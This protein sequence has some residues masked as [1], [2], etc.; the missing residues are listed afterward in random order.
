MARFVIVGAGL[1]G[2]KA[3][4][5]LRE[6]GLRRAGRADRRRARTPLRAAAAVQGLP[7]GQDR[8]RDK[9]FVH[10][11]ELVRRARR[12]TAARARGHARSTRAAHTRRRSA[13]GDR[14]GYDKLLLATGSRRA[15]LA[16]P[17]RRPRRRAL[18]APLDDSDRLRGRAARRRRGVVVDRRRLD[19]AGGRRRRPRRPAPR[20]P[21]RAAPTCRC[22]A[23]SAPEL[24]A[25][26]RRPAPRA[27]RRPAARRRRRRDHRRRTAVRPAYAW[28][29][30]PRS[31][32]DAV[33]VG[34]GAAPERRARRG[35]RP[36]RRQ[37]R[38]WSTRAC[39][40]QRP[41]HLRRR[42]RRQRRPPAA[43]HAHPRRA[44]GQRA[45]PAGRPRPRAMLGQDADLRPSCRTSSPTSTTSAWSTSA[46]P[47][48]AA[49]TRS[50]SAATSPAREF[51]AFWLRGRPGAR[52]DERQRL[53][54]H[55]RRS[56][57]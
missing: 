33:V 21:S 1:A 10:D 36:R 23:C 44:L 35:R 30:A 15:R 5:A 56:R 20:S 39:A 41:G 19:R 9:V 48:P 17:R 55:R 54:R 25:G 11:D 3:A 43:G 51:I 8:A 37:R 7:A 14:L 53:G 57:R 38:R 22:S 32:A 42:R 2:A 47:R 49:T 50:S 40:R 28:P 31:P 34:V 13:D 24:G 27:R 46:T 29:T 6:R 26:V 45:Q 18:P 52:R 12:R 16:D 4:E